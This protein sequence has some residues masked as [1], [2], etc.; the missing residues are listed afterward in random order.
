MFIPSHC[1]QSDNEWKTFFTQ[2]TNSPS[3]LSEKALPNVYIQEFSEPL[4]SMKQ[5]CQNGRI[6]VSACTGSGWDEVNSHHSSLYGALLTFVASNVGSTPVFCP[7]LISAYTIPRP[8]LFL[9][10]PALTPQKNY[11]GGKQENGRG[12]VGQLTWIKARSHGIMLSKKSLRKGKEL[13]ERNIGAYVVFAS[14]CCLWWGSAL[15][16]V[17]ECLPVDEKQ[18]I[19]SLF[20]FTCT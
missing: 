20:C 10:G 5:L 7:L 15:E 11:P 12:T 4:H 9:S 3:S 13:E 2:S 14:H 18:S 1:L 19:S 16:E 8:S 6:W 17:A